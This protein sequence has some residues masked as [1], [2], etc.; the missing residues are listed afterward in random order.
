MD[1]KDLMHDL[2]LMLLYLD[3]WKEKGPSGPVA[4]SWNRYDS[5][6]LQA[7]QNE[8]LIGPAQKAKPIA[9]TPDGEDVAGMLVDVYRTVIGEFQDEVVDSLKNAGPFTN[10]PAFR[11]R[12][13]LKLDGRACWREIVVPQSFTFSDLH[14]VIQ[15]SFLWWDYHM[16]DFQLTNRREKL[17]IIDPDAGGIDGMFAPGTEGRKAV[18]ATKT[19]LDDVFPR[20]RTATYTYDYGD[21]WVH[22]IRLVET[23]DN[24]AGEMPVCTAGDGDAPPEDVGGAGGFEEFLRAIADSKD[25][26]HNH[27][28]AWGKSQGFEHFDLKRANERLHKWLTGEAFDEWDR[29][30]SDEPQLGGATGGAGAKGGKGKSGAKGATGSSP[31]KL[32]P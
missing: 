10:E 13:E 2:T 25:P 30:H 21:Y 18:D 19:Y 14:Q 8:G 26:D 31:F 9:L 24:Y 20:T 29:M 17:M 3:S 11:F 22:K 4:R 12:I 15:G 7:L 5:N 6:V 28:L 23:I 16:Y 27:M 1:D 32:V